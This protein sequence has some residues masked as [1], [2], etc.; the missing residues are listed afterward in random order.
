MQF[1]TLIF[2]VYFVVVLSGTW[3]LARQRTLQKL[4]LLAASYFFYAYANWMMLAVLVVSSLINYCAGELIARSIERPRRRAWLV[5][6]VVC[7]LI[8]LGVFKYYGFFVESVA[9][10]L[11]SIGLKPSLPALE[12][13]L[14]LG[15]S[16]YTFQGLSYIIDLYRK[17]GVRA[18]SLL[19]FLLFVAYFPKLLSGPICRAK[20]LLPQLAGPHPRGIADLSS[21]ATLILSG[22]F[23]KVVLATLIDT[24]LVLKVFDAPEN[25]SAPALWMGMFG[26]AFL[27]YWD[28]SGY[29]DLARGLSQLLGFKLP[30]NFTY[31]Y[32]ASDISD[33]WRRWHITLSNWLRDYLFI[34]LGGMHLTKR[35]SAVVLTMVLAGLWHGAGWTYVLWGTFHGLMLFF[36]HLFRSGIKRKWRGGWLGRIGTFVLVCFG[37]VLFRAEDLPAAI[38]YFGRMFS[39]SAQGTG[40]EG[41]VVALLIIGI[42][43]HLMS[44]RL[45]RS[46]T[47]ISERIPFALRPVLW[48]AMGMLILALKPAGIAPYIY[49][50]F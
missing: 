35:W 4:F 7:N 36:H 40:F 38:A 47:S 41:L 8:L 22:L 9:V 33:F 30:E 50:G 12:I 44:G 15:I 17:Q 45:K 18:S 24:H 3:L 27:L 26:Y 23:K 39:F 32:M 1:T 19:D 48:F 34:P 37:W 43:L 13:L 11:E 5:A 21:T 31:P 42:V 14:P 16:F 20:E 46:M 25:Y 2:A 28:F 29:T 49:F 6:G 10:L